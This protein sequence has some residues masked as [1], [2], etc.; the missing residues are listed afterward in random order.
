MKKSIFSKMVSCI[1]LFI[2]VSA[3]LLFAQAGGTI[4]AI[5]ISGNKNINT[6]TIMN[7][8][9][10]K[11]GDDATDANIEKGRDAI[12]DLGYFSVVTIHKEVEDGG[13][14]IT[15]EV[16][17]Y[18][19]ISD[20]K[21]EGSD[22]ILPATI[23]E[24]M[25]TKPGQVL[26]DSTLNQDIETIQTYY[27]DAGYIAYV[28]EDIAVDGETGVLTIPILVHKVEEIE[29]TGLKKTKE[30]I[31][32]REMETKP[33]G[34]FNVKTLREDVIEIYNLDLFEDIQQY[35][36]SPGEEMGGVKIVIPVVEKKTGRVSFG[37]GYSSKQRL[38][39]QVS[40][41]ESNFRGRGQGIN[42]LYEQG[43]TAAVGGRYSYEVGFFEPWIDKKNTSLSLNLYNRIRYRFSSGVF[44]SST[45]SDDD[46]Y[47]ERRKGVTATVGRPLSKKTELFLTT[48]FENV[49]TNP[50]LL[51]LNLRNNLITIAQ[52][53]DVYSGQLKFVKNTRDVDLDPAAGT[54]SAYAVEIGHGDTIRHRLVQTGIDANGN[55]TYATQP[56]ELSGMYQKLSVDLRK[57]FSK[58]GAKTAINDKR[59]TIAIRLRA[60]ISSG[61]IPFFE[62][63]FI[64]GGESLRGYREDRFWGERMLLASVE[65]RK[66]IAQ[67]VAGVLFCD[68][69]SAWGGDKWYNV[70][71]LKQTDGFKGHFSGGVGL[72]VNTPI[73]NLRLDYGYGSEGGRT[74]FSIGQA[75]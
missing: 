43:T 56:S 66:P 47:N 60:G 35:Q 67:S 26:N 46:F 44:N 55:P 18:N 73:G 11:V 5:G 27:G 69:G 13:V 63:F 29:F 70:P 34:Y 1:M 61:D 51:S 10:I 42:L 4:S 54:Y 38:V 28:T 40:V 62:Q 20:I 59:T 72:R 31:L 2:F 23:L 53:G 48:K 58:G 33:G 16:T 68:Y 25:R 57:Y 52:D 49:E 75:F 19:K 30:Y 22:P 45:D 37:L 14:K 65:L 8:V 17:E 3:Q 12:M 71:S 24:I 41:S 64:G 39:G 9:G 36:I 32:L 7:V 15:Y 74:H 6:D 21:I 50:E